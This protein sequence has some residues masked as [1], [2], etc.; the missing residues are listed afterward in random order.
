V[1]ATVYLHHRFQ[2]VAVAKLV[3]GYEY[4]HAVEGDGQPAA[5]PVSGERQ[6]RAIQA[7]LETLSPAFLDIPEET[8]RKIAPRT[9]E[10]PSS[11]AQFAN[12]TGAA[13]AALGAA[14]SAADL[15]IRV[16]LEPSRAARMVDFHR[17]A[18][19][20]PDLTELLSTLVERVFADT[21]S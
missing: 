21:V 7:I 17:R 5:K 6:R 18:P 9:P 11:R 14:A 1:L 3:G 10:L 4:R 2:T 13:F 20:T 8:L 15:S 19:S 16:L 12:R